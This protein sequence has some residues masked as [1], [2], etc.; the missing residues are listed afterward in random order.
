MAERLKLS[1]REYELT[2]P[3]I[4][5]TWNSQTYYNIAQNPKSTCTR[6]IFYLKKEWLK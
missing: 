6:N 3:F 1:Q 4:P 2:N 5:G